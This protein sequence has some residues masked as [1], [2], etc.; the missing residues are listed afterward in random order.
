VGKKDGEK[1]RNT[2]RKV[3]RNGLMAPRKFFFLYK[4][5]AE[6]FSAKYED[7]FPNRQFCY[8]TR[9]KST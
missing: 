1:A 6:S 8:S 5:D 9:F 7:L 4:I 3:V 2:H